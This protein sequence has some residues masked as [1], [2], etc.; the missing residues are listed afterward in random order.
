[1][2]LFDKL[3]DDMIIHILSFLP[4]KYAV[5]TSVLSRRWKFLWCY[6]TKTLEFDDRLSF[7]EK[8]YG[9]KNT[10]RIQSFSNFVDRVIKLNKVPEIDKFLLM[11]DH[12]IPRS[13]RPLSWIEEIVK[14]NKVKEIEIYF[15][16]RARGPFLSLEAFQSTHLRVL[17]L[18][19]LD[20]SALEGFPSRNW[21][22]F[23]LPNLK[24]LDFWYYDLF[25][26][27][28]LLIHLFRASPNLEEANFG[29]YIGA[30][31]RVFFNIYAPS[32]KRLKMTL[33]SSDSLDKFFITAPVLEELTVVDN[34]FHHYVVKSDCIVNVKL[35]IGH[36]DFSQEKCLPMYINRALKLLCRISHVKFLHLKAFTVDLKLCFLNY[37]SWDILSKL[38]EC[39]PN[40]QVLSLSKHFRVYDS[41]FR[42]DSTWIQPSKVPV[43]LVSRL[44][45]VEV[46]DCECHQ[47]E[48]NLISYLLNHGEVLS[49][50]LVELLPANSREDNLRFKD[51]LMMVP[52]VS[53]TCQLQISAFPYC[54]SL[55]S[56]LPD[57][58]EQ[59]CPLTVQQPPQELCYEDLRLCTDYFSDE[60]LMARS[61]NFKVYRGKFH[62]LGSTSRDVVVKKWI[63]LAESPYKEH[64]EKTICRFHEELKLLKHANFKS[65]PY[66][67]SI[68]GYC[69]EDSSERLGVV[70]DFKPLDSLENLIPKDNFSWLQRI[71]VALVLACILEYMHQKRGDL[72]FVN[73]KITPACVILDQDYMPVLYNFNRKVDVFDTYEGKDKGDVETHDI[74]SWK[75]VDVDRYG[76]TLFGLISKRAHRCPLISKRNNECPVTNRHR[77]SCITLHRWIA[78]QEFE[79]DC[80]SKLCKSQIPL[81]H[82][83]LMEDSTYHFVDGL[84]L[85]SIAMRCFGE[86]RDMPS[87][88]EI[89]NSL[90]KLHVVRENWDVLNRDGVISKYLNMQRS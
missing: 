80:T 6:A 44:S 48:F 86:I 9:Y 70:Y 53:S 40:L 75:E 82:K 17:K 84:K 10:D 19:I 64:K 21:E 83:D 66:L 11:F 79:R 85:S 36:P 38:L 77:L 1:M 12:C 20:P 50:F 56:S 54:S 63:I 81:V 34:L 90:C 46:W 37:S 41:E 67:K 33:T 88:H 15:K 76:V 39:A 13:N 78:I 32:L 8:S 4:T 65:H 87:M 51:E 29:G 30:D 49:D 24:I 16:P 69:I 2:D 26:R 71:K 58:G 25:N 89:I 35:D 28:Y 47:V 45:R 5:L 31:K 23:F 57:D 14:R 73:P 68:I 27:W 43:C 72:P 7:D 18:H 61:K 59:V 62:Q 52:R 42:K 3:G 55:S 60:N 22:A 74:M